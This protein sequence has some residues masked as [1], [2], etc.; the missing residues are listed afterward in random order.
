MSEVTMEVPLALQQLVTSNNKLLKDYQA[1]LWRQIEQANAEMMQ[2]LR[3][4]PSAGWRLDIERMLYVRI[5]NEPTDEAPA[6]A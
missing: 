4:D 5:E 3:L 6:D 2:I 1:V